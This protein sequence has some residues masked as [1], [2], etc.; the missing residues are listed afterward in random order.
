MSRY[1]SGEIIKGTVSG[2]ENYGIFIK[3]DD[4][5][6]GLIHISEISDGFVRNIEDYVKIGD[7][8]YAEVL[9][10]DDNSHQAKLSI[11]NISYRV[12]T[13]IEK[14]KIVET[15]LGFKT[16]EKNLP[17]WIEENIKKNKKEINSIDK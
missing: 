3:I 14:K 7:I 12:G 6:N 1:K 5:Y 15:K 4:F 13:R 8:I 17:I 16:L 11:K 2:I 9:E 10:I